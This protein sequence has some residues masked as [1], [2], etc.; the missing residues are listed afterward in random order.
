MTVIIA[1]GTGFLG[2]ALID[3]LLARGDKVILLTRN[4]AAAHLRWDAKVDVRLWNAKDPGPW[5]L[6]FEKADAVIN[7]AGENVA[8]DRWT[9]ERKLALI[10]SR[11]DPTRAIVAALAAASKRPKVFVCA[12][13][14]GY[15]GGARK[16]DSPEDAPQGTDFLAA[17]CGQWERE[18]QAA[19]KL[20]VRAVMPRIG[21]V[22]EKDGGALAKMLPPF[23]FGVGGRLGS[24]RQ[25]FPWIHRD[26]VVGGI[27][28]LLE[29]NISGPVNLA[30]PD[31]KTNAAFTKALGRALHRPA[32]FPVP[33]FVLK[34]AL[35]EM[36]AMLLGGQRA[37]PKKLLD[38]GYQ[39]KYPEI[40]K[41][42]AAI[43]K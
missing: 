5:V 28:F 8:S 23:K 24:G 39:F 32:F 16:G 11:I 36:S 29:K 42:L 40:D 25:A 33:G 15:Y 27:L 43:L 4:P 21:V 26:D 19:E 20:G 17:L 3:A 18:A 1:G 22:L 2:S 35:G 30:A 31:L 13:A 37:I 7:L 12:S 38:A 6:A 14:V 10:K 34:L 9:T 41:A